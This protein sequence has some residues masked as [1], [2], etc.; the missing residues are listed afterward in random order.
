MRDKDKIKSGMIAAGVSPKTAD[1]ILSSPAFDRDP[2]EIEKLRNEI[3]RL[4]TNFNAAEYEMK[5]ADRNRIFFQKEYERWMSIAQSQSAYITELKEAVGRYV[6]TVV[7]YEGITFIDGVHD[8][9]AKLIMS[10]SD[11]WMKRKEKE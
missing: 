11:E 7:G 8:D 1:E 10:V 3:K 6:E 4:T 5:V 2:D 9:W